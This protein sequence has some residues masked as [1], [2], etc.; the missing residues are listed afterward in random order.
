M[1]VTFSKTCP[2]TEQVHETKNNLGSGPPGPQESSVLSW[3][4]KSKPGG[5]GGSSYSQGPNS[6]PDHLLT[7]AKKQ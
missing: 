1:C 5:A 7:V 2:E 4:R 6:H 3:G